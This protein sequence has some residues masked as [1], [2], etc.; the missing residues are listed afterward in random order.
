MGVGLELGSVKM[1]SE[2]GLERLEVALD[3]SLLPCLEGV[4]GSYLPVCSPGCQDCELRQKAG[5]RTAM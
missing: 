2:L 1:A 5:V 3:L 4:E